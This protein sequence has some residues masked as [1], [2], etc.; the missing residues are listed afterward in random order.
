MLPHRAPYGGEET[1][2]SRKTVRARQLIVEQN[3]IATFATL[4]PRNTRP[5]TTQSFSAGAS[6]RQIATPGED[7][8]GGP[9]LNPAAAPWVR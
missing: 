9:Q 6:D 5:T 7:V 3:Y 2:R 8:F 1:I 4:V